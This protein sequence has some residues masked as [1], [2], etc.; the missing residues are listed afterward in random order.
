MPRPKT[1]VKHDASVH[2][3]GPQRE[4]RAEPPITQNDLLFRTLKQIADALVATFPRAF[5]VV[6]HDLSQPR[7]SIKQIAGDITC[8]KSGGPLTDLVGQSLA[9]GTGAYQRD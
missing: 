1:T 9:Q 7:K 4:N 6:V 5:E 2:Q 3:P 8:R